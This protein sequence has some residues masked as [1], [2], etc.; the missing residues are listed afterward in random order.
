VLNYYVLCDYTPKKRPL[1]LQ[2]SITYYSPITI[3]FIISLLSHI[4]ISEKDVYKHELLRL[5]STALKLKCNKVIK[6]VL[7]VY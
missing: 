7:L 3:T 6:L 5:F 2:F 4:I 1:P